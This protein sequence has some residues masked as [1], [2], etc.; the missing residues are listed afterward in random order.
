MA[1]SDKYFTLFQVAALLEVSTDDVLDLVVGRIG[2]RVK[3]NHINILTGDYMCLE[4]PLPVYANIGVKRFKVY[5]KKKCYRFSLRY[6]KYGL[7]RYD[8]YLSKEVQLVGMIRIA[9]L[10]V[11]RLGGFVDVLELSDYVL[12]PRYGLFGRFNRFS[13]SLSE[14]LVDKRSFYDWYLSRWGI[15]ESCFS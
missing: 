1:V 15:A 14:L 7:R 6:L 11:N 2:Q 12:S 3:S 5:G 10:Q 13:V 8:M 9:R 4:Q